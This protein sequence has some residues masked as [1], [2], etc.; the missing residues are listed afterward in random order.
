LKICYGIIKESGREGSSESTI[1]LALDATGTLPLT[2]STL[3]VATA[4]IRLT[5]NRKGAKEAAERPSY[6]VVKVGSRR[7]REAYKGTF[8][9]AEKT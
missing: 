6:T 7:F 1:S 9:G 4:W 8:G 2:F 3:D 5:R